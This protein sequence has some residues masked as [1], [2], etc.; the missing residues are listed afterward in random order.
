[1]AQGASAQ[2]AIRALMGGVPCLLYV[3]S[4][5]LLLRFGLNEREHSEIRSALDARQAAA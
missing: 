2:L 3:V 5:L 4:A 1:M